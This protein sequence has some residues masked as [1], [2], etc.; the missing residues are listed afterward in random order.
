[1]KSLKDYVD[2]VLANDTEEIKL[3]S[4]VS[5]KTQVFWCIVSYQTQKSVQMGADY[6]VQKNKIIIRGFH[7]DGGDTAFQNRAY[8]V[9]KFRKKKK[10]MLSV[11]STYLY[12]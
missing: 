2:A 10:K 5:R 6:C 4:I 11:I 1:M 7:S 9:S 12:E 8:S 3:V